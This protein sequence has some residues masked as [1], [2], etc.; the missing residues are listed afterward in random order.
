MI[1]TSGIDLSVAWNLNLSAILLTQL[2]AVSG[3]GQLAWAIVVALG[4]AALVGLLNGL[5]VA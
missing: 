1:L 4:S 5:G 3:C 2:A